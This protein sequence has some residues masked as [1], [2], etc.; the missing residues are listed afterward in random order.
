MITQ[1]QAKAKVRKLLQEQELCD[2]ILIIKC[3]FSETTTYQDI[4]NNDADILGELNRRRVK[5]AIQPY[6]DPGQEE[7]IAQQAMMIGFIL[8]CEALSHVS[9]GKSGKEWQ[10]HWLSQALEQMRTMSEE[11]LTQYLKESTASEIEIYD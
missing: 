4:C 9:P 8:A 11:E 5:A 10:V 2:G 7:L 6:A 3:P 1:Q